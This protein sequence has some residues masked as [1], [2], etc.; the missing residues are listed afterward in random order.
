MPGDIVRAELVDEKGETWRLDT[1]PRVLQISVETERPT[2]PFLKLNKTQ[3]TELGFGAYFEG[4]A[5][6]TRQLKVNVR[7]DA[8]CRV[9]EEVPL[10]AHSLGTSDKEGWVGAQ[11]RLIFV[12]AAEEGAKAAGGTPARKGRKAKASRKAK[13]KSG[14]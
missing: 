13:T 7:S 4:K 12:R 10:A 11:L 8:T 5:A 1:T 6:S 3:V 14:R 2:H 9:G